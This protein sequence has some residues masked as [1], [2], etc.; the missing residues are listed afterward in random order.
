MIR[1]AVLL[2]GRGDHREYLASLNRLEL[3]LPAIEL[4]A[5]EWTSRLPTLPSVLPGWSVEVVHG[6]TRCSSTFG[7]L[8]AFDYH[9]DA[10]KMP[11]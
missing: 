3:V 9:C 5:T 4:A 6:D 1:A 8:W 2:P 10:G 7:P 11:L